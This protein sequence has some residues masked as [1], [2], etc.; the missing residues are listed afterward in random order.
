MRD[1]ASSN[2]RQSA[3]SAHRCRL[4]IGAERQQDSAV[5][6]FGP[7]DEITI[8]HDGSGSRKQSFIAWQEALRATLGSISAR[9]SFER[10]VFADPCSPAMGKTG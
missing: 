8:E 6:Q 3:C 1:R 7:N 2:S 4:P 9:R 10:M 5:R